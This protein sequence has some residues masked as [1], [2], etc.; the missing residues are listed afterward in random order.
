LGGTTLI[1]SDIPLARN[2][3]TKARDNRIPKN[4]ATD[5]NREAVSVKGSIGI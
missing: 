3:R 4:V 2:A 1:R 5:Q